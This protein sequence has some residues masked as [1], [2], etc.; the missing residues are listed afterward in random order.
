[1]KKYIYTLIALF[2]INLG[3]FA[4]NEVDALRYGQFN[5]VG[6]ARYTALGG[7]FGALGADM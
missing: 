7:A 3:L 5:S 6:T 2:S 4:Q 1:M